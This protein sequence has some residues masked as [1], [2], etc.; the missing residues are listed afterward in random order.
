MSGATSERGQRTRVSLSSSRSGLTRRGQRAIA[1]SWLI[2]SSGRATLAR[3][4]GP[5]CRANVVLLVT[6]F[7]KGKHTIA[8]SLFGCFDPK[9]G[10]DAGRDFYGA[11]GSRSTVGWKKSFR[12]ARLASFRSAPVANSSSSKRTS[13]A[14]KLQTKSGLSE[15]PRN[16]R[17]AGLSW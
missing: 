16:R 17:A 6:V 4:T 5:V 2:A 3:T 12:R 1:L 15:W 13:R 8:R 14:R 11:V 9:G 10:R 7:R